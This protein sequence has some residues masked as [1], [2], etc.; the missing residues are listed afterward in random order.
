MPYTLQVEGMEEITAMLADVENSAQG[1]AALALYEG[2]GI[3]ADA[4][5][6]GMLVPITHSSRFIRLNIK[7]HPIRLYEVIS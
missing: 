2:A 4:I 7:N 6:K 5:S 3:V 1:I